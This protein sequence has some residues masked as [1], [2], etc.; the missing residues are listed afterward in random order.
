MS[1]F[2]CGNGTKWSCVCA[3][4]LRARGMVP[5]GAQRTKLRTVWW[6]CWHVLIGARASTPST[7][8][9][10]TTLH[11]SS[12]RQDHVS[13]TSWNF[14]TLALYGNTIWSPRP[15]GQIRTVPHERDCRESKIPHPC[16]SLTSSQLPRPSHTLS[17]LFRRYPSV[18][19][20]ISLSRRTSGT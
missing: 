19:C 9:D 11:M 20:C 4:R 6:K 5:V 16:C 12:T 10:P 2:R 18:P 1:C 15:V 14:S 8:H 7:T 17:T 13:G 3:D